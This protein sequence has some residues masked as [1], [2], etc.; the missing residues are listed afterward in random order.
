MMGEFLKRLFLKRTA[1]PPTAEPN[2]QAPKTGQHRDEPGL[3]QSEENFGQL[4]SGLRDYAIFLLDQRGH[5]LSWNAGAEAIKGYSNDEI[6]GQHFSRFYNEESI[7]SDW[8]QHEL[9]VASTTGRYEEEGWRVR[10]NGSQFWANVVI[11]ALRDESGDVRGY[12]KIVRDI[13]ERKRVEEELRLSEERFRL[14]VEGVQDYAIFMLDPDGRVATWNAG[15]QNIKGYTADEII[16]Q[17][18][19]RFYPT[20]VIESGWPAEELRQAAAQ[21]RFED[22]GWRVRKDGSKFWANVVITALRDQSGTLRGFTKVTRDMTERQQAEE[23]AR[24]LLQEEAARQAAEASAKEAQQ[25][26]TEERRQRERFLVTLASIGDGVIVTDEK[27]HVTFLNRVAQQLTGWSLP[28]AVGKPL[29]VVFRIID[30]HTRQP[31]ENPVVKALR[32]KEIIGLA[33]HT[34]LI[35]KDGT[36]RF[37][38]DS[39]APIQE[40]DGSVVGGVIVFRDVSQRRAAQL[41]Q[42]RLASLVDSSGDAILG[43]TFDGAVTDWNAGAERLFGF[44]VNEVVGKSIFSSIVPP[45][46][47]DELMQ[48][49][50]R[51]QQGARIDP[52]E[53]IRRDKAGRR[54]PVSIRISPILDDEG[55]VI[56]ASAIDRDITQQRANDRRRNA[57]VSVTQILANEPDA[58]KAIKDILAAVC[59]ALEWDTGCFWQLQPGQNE[60]RCQAFWQEPSRNIEAFRD[61]SMRLAFPAG[62]SL[63]G[64]VWERRRAVW[65]PDVTVDPHFTRA[66]Q[67]SQVG[68]H[69]GFACPVIVGEKFMGV[70]EWFSHEI[71]EPDDDLLEMMMTVG[72]QIGQFLERREAEQKLR[73]SEKELNDF[74]ENAAV[75]LHWAGPDGVILR[76]NQAVLKMLGYSR[77]EYVGHNIAEFHVDQDAIQG[78][79]Q[80]LMADE[81]LHDYEANLRCKDGSIKQVLVDSNVLWDEGQFVHT[82]CITRDIT[83]RKKA[84]TALQDSEER[85]RLALEAG[86]MGSWEWHIPTGNVIWSTTLEQIHGLAPGSFGGTF[87]AFQQD[88]HPED[89]QRVLD[90]IQQTVEQG[91]DHHLE[92]RIVRP[93]GGVRWLEARG[94]LFRD[95]NDQPLRLLGICSDATE[96]KR[97][98]QSLHFLA[99]A[100]KS[101]S[102][103]IDF[104]STL[105][106]VA[107]LAVPDFADWCAVEML[108][109]DGSLQRLVVAHAD[110]AK[111]ELAEELY[112]RYPPDPESPRGVFNVLRTGESEF[113]TEI[114]DELLQLSAR[115]EAHLAIMR[116]L[117]LK[118]YMCV[119]LRSKS[120]VLG[121]MTF[122][123]GESGRRYVAADL[124]MAEDLAHR[125]AI[126]IENARLYQQVRDADHRKDEFLAMLA[127]ELRNPLAPI[128]SGL[129]IL[130]MDAGEHSETVALMQEQVEHI[131]RLVDD[132]LDVSRIMRGKVELRK[133]P[134]EVADL[135]RRSVQTVQPLINSQQQ[136]LVV[137]VPERPIWIDAD[138]VRIVQVLENLLNNGSKYTDVGGRIELTVERQDN[139]AVIKVTDTGVGLEPELLPAIFELFTQS[140]RSLDRAQGG[141]GIGLTLVKSLV[142]MHGGT[143]TAHSDGPGRGSTFVVRLP[144]IESPRPTQDAAERPCM[145]EKCRILV[146]DDNV[147]AARLLT[148]LLMKLDGHEVEIAYDGPTALS[149]IKEFHPEIVLLDIGL[150]GMDGYQVGR[151]VREMPE[152]DDLLLVALTGYGQEEDR[153]R[154]RQAGFDEHLVKPPS[155]EQIRGLLTHPKLAK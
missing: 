20:D 93:D 110:P 97:L 129:E 89:R 155:V 84:E 103:L 61:T 119:P 120:S 91:R 50:R 19:S 35:A 149:K 79:L 73:R 78:I 102:L 132:L 127:H 40:Q 63:P 135:V 151:A 55:H 64:R 75:G 69:G 3:R 58:E 5:V 59:S 72:S 47:K 133:A 109:V 112:R 80:C 81:Q 17:H 33:N 67:A 146:V 23:N 76:A 152:F 115:D 12:L 140:S 4:V 39:A 66:S 37:I 32:E 21:G 138:P 101:L 131:V 8:P 125:A 105:Q 113:M 70:I 117:S 62:S 1:D 57:R 111:V 9:E 52:F 85:L 43:V 11:T 14:L 44:S 139:Q 77:E 96:R 95:Q 122:V 153:K 126:A 136:Q 27:A 99:E 65:I 31:T 128:R 45:D 150:P 22:E 98:E 83:E 147:G 28:E 15:A 144:E 137:A 41:A 86:R 121:V 60:L 87:E 53:S 29:D 51:V 18:F 24:R 108:E 48:V 68:L 104:R 34:I 54:I 82:R 123:G 26:R 6:I 106:N 145:T 134:N 30:E 90:L 130:A 114:P 13:T 16:G 92:Y 124:V 74:F 42:G 154:S 46:R 49:L 94:K 88:I 10:K 141:L 36:E 142:E 100:S 116:K 71:R 56:G 38:D 2:V 25:A 107:N 143:V 148:M 118:S 7:S